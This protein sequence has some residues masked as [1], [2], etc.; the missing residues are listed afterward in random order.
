MEEINEEP[1]N[2]LVQPENVVELNDVEQVD[3]MDQA[4]STEQADG[5]EQADETEQ[6]NDSGLGQC[7]NLPISRERLVQAI[8]NATPNPTCPA[9]NRDRAST[10]MKLS[11]IRSRERRI[12]NDYTRTSF[13][14]E[15]EDGK[16]VVE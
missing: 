12:T 5:T 3:E 7:E 16:F 15:R 2:N 10:A 4:D 8:T 13:D 14:W 11:A 6:A 1:P 9:S